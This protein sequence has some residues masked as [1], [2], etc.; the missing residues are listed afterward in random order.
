MLELLHIGG[1]SKQYRW[2][3]PG[4]GDNAYINNLQNAAAARSFGKRCVLID[5]LDILTRDQ[6][7]DG[8]PVKPPERITEE[9]ARQIGDIVQA[10]A[11]KEPKIGQTFPK[12]LKTE[13][14]AESAAALYGGD[15]YEAVM[16]MLR[17][18]MRNLGIE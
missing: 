11:E 18:K 8:M 2:T 13:F 15:Q 5:A 4:M 9:Q 7:S 12:W 16:D 6:D 10:C 14:G 3:L 1:H 17:A